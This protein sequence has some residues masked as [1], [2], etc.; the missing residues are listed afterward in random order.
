[1]YEIS[2]VICQKLNIIGG[3]YTFSPISLYKFQTV[4]I[5][6][7]KLPIFNYNLL[8]RYIR[9]FNKIQPLNIH[10]NTPKPATKMCKLY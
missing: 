5:V 4:N 10:T 2:N 3:L 8:Q 9:N 6:I 1:M 7:C